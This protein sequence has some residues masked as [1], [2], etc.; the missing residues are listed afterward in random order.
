MEFEEIIDSKPIKKYVYNFT[1][2]QEIQS[3]SNVGFTLDS[4]GFEQS[5]Y[6]NEEAT[7]IT[8]TE[9]NDF[10]IVEFLGRSYKLSIDLFSSLDLVCKE[11]IVKNHKFDV[12]EFRTDKQEDFN[13]F[14]CDTVPFSIVNKGKAMEG[15]VDINT[16]EMY[17]IY[18]NKWFKLKNK[19]DFSKYITIKEY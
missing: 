5:S 15:V 8:V 12:D 1:H 11:M 19:F 9:F 13:S 3:H 18:K 2:K 16:G 6:T 7:D 10:I 14:I 17:V 4:C